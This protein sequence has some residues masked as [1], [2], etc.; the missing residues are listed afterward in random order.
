[1]DTSTDIV[2]T[3]DFHLNKI[4][5]QVPGGVKL[6]FAEIFTEVQEISDTNCWKLT[7]FADIMIS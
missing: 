1:M 3:V 4:V 6:F 7:Y 2:A 5:Y